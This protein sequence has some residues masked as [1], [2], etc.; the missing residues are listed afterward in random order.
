MKNFL[1]G[2]LLLSFF[3]AKSQDNLKLIKIKQVEKA[4]YELSGFTVHPQ[5]GII[6]IEDEHPYVSQLDTNTWKLKKLFKVHIK[7]D[8]TDFEGVDVC[9]NDIFVLSEQT[10]TAYKVKHHWAKPV[11]VNYTDWEKENKVDLHIKDWHNAGYEGLAFDSKDSLLYLIKERKAEHVDDGRFIFAVDLKTSKILKRFTLPEKGRNTDFSDAKFEVHDSVKYLYLIERNNY[12][13][14]RINLSDFS[15]VQYSF[16]KYMTDADGDLNMYFSEHPEYGI[17]EALILFPNQIW[18]GL[19]N[20]QIT[21]NQKNKY[22]KKYHLKGN[23]PAV[24]IF[25]RPKNF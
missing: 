3:S 10:S 21:V 4:A 7:A 20:N 11:K 13:V 15:T 5:L 1:L 9:G 23:A 14:V 8:Y 25:K 18:I 2:L 17:A 16:K 24:L 19:D 6:C 12:S 22:T